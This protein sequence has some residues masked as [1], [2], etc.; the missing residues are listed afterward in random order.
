MEPFLETKDIQGN[1]EPG[2][3]MP[4]QKIYA[5]RISKA[6]ETASLVRYLLPMVTSMQEAMDFHE[7][8]INKAK[9]TGQFG[10]KSYQLITENKCWLNVSL[11][12]DLLKKLKIEA[13]SEQ[14]SSFAAGLYA[15]SKSLGDPTN[16]DNPGNPNK[17][18]VGYGSNISDMFLIFAS[19]SSDYLESRTADILYQM[20]SIATFEIIYQERAER[21]A[22]DTEHFGFKDGISQPDIRGVVQTHP[23]VYYNPRTI[24]S[25]NNDPAQPEY[26]SPGRILLWPGQFIFGYPVQSDV[27]YRDPVMVTTDPILKNGSFLVFRRLRQLVKEF[28][29][30]TDGVAASLAKLDTCYAKPDYLRSKIIGRDKASSNSL[31]QA[32]NTNPLLI[33]HFLYADSLVDMQL[34]D[35]TTVTSPVSDP[36]GLVCPFFAHIRKVNPRDSITNRWNDRNTLK[37][38]IMRRGIPFG[39]KYDHEN[40]ANP[41]NDQERGLLFLSYQ[42]KINQFEILINDWVNSQANPE[43]GDGID[44]LIGQQRPLGDANSCTAKLTVN[45]QPFQLS[46]MTDFVVPTG[47]EYLFTP[48][49]TL[50]KKLSATEIKKDD[51]Q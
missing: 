44:M 19:N 28:Y 50:L 10:F 26:S 49:I 33:N 30:Y 13:A 17:W 9:T 38:R 51:K 18:V 12:R 36:L 8:R 25:G 46:N 29:A 35:G 42:T 22:D 20:Q 34:Q 27:S 15:K 3:R 1:I 23:V 14:D 48:S 40:T 4:F 11:G 6:T 21:L 41:S 31:L 24:V 39:P 47:G 5:L 7:I 43:A 37:L 2:F 32:T 45:G 16:I